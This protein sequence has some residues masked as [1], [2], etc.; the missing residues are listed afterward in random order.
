MTRQFLGALSALALAG[1]VLGGCQTAEPEPPPEPDVTRPQPIVDSTP[2]PE[3]PDPG[4]R[5]TEDLEPVTHEGKLLDTTFYFEYDQ[6]RLAQADI[7]TLAV[8]AEILRKYRNRSA[9]IEGHCDE[10]GTREYNL[11]L[12]ERRSEAVRRYL[13]S[14][15]VRATQLETVSYGEERPVDPGHDESAWAQ[16]RRAVM[17]YR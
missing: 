10:R 13:I 16:N 1:V 14:A 9:H 15:G 6:A 2:P 3:R 12:G 17:I 8:H 11:A 7:A 5:L 4:P